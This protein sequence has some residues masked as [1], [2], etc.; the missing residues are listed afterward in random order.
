MCKDYNEQN[1]N[2]IRK[3]YLVTYSTGTYDMYYVH[4]D[5]VFFSYERAM[6]RAEELR[7]SF[8]P[9]KSMFVP[10][11]DKYGD[12]IRDM[13]EEDREKTFW[14]CQ[15]KADTYR[16]EHEEE[17]PDLWKENMT[18]ADREAW[19]KQEELNDIRYNE[20]LKNFISEVYPK[21]S[22]EDIER[23]IKI[24]EDNEYIIEQEYGSVDIE[25]IYIDENE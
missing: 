10:D 23:A 3:G 8:E 15:Y 19:D 14:S 4:N 22:N 16:E 17:F 25:E 18:K 13:S 9:K 5:K 6:E 21:W 24:E 20:I 12:L 7:K 1:V 11:R 2:N